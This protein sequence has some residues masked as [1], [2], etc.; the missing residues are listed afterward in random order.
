M[1]VLVLV[2]EKLILEA[3]KIY[4]KIHKKKVFFNQVKFDQVVYSGGIAISI[5]GKVLSPQS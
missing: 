5:V 2:Q 1:G 3:T 4:T